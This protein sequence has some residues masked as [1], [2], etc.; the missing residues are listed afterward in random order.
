MKKLIFVLTLIISAME[1]RFFVGVS[2]GYLSTNTSYSFAGALIDI[3]GT[4]PQLED[5]VEREGKSKGNGGIISLSLGTE[6]F[7]HTDYIGWRWELAGG[8]GHYFYK[9]MLS[10]QNTQSSLLFAEFNSDVLV[11]FYVKPQKFS[12]G[13]F[14]GTGISWQKNQPK[15]PF[16]IFTNPANPTEPTDDVFN[17]VSLPIRAGFTMLID[18][19]HRFEAYAVLPVELRKTRDIAF[20]DETYQVA[21]SYEY[22]FS[23]MKAVFSYKYV[24]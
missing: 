8:Y 12:F 11:N 20:V 14:L 18:N 21:T 6:H 16:E 1:A 17:L 4:A 19:H 7:P 9:H 13:I 23:A 24:F 3:S 2:G 5:Y 10:E 22:R 15:K